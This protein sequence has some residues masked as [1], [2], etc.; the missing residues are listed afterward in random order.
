M[1]YSGERPHMP[2]VAAKALRNDGPHA[3]E[4]YRSVR[5]VQSIDGLAAVDAG[6]D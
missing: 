1:D 2:A 3:L 5:N 6:R 4:H